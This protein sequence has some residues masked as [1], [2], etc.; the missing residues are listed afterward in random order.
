MEQ[1]DNYGTNVRAIDE[2]TV[3]DLETDN[4]IPTHEMGGRRTSS[5]KADLTSD[6]YNN[7]CSMAG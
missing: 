5:Q 7:A 4:A 6:L 2:L 1:Q 3:V